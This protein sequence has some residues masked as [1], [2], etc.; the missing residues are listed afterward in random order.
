MTKDNNR[1][2]GT[3]WESSKHLER[4]WQILTKIEITEICVCMCVWERERDREGGRNL[5]QW[6]RYA[7]NA[8]GTFNVCFQCWF[9]LTFQT[10]TNGTLQY[11]FPLSRHT[12]ILPPRFRGPQ[13]PPAWHHSW[14]T[15]LFRVPCGRVLSEMLRH[16]QTV[17]VTFSTKIG[18]LVWE[19]PLLQGS[20][21]FFPRLAGPHGGG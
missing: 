1:G 18:P 4:T 19:C 21:P 8:A 17:L 7:A 5:M 15:G 9:S 3:S 14:V 12:R 6:R 16:W 11:G 13:K 2:R 20:S 10:D